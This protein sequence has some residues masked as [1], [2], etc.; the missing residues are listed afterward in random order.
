[1]RKLKNPVIDGH[2]KCGVCHTVKPV[3]AFSMKKSLHGELFHIS[4]C[5]E[6]ICVYSTKLK[7]SLGVQPKKLYPIID[8]C[9]Q[10]TLCDKVKPVDQFGKMTRNISGLR[11]ACKECELE[12]SLIY[13]R[14]QGRV[15]NTFVVHP[16]IDGIKKCHICLKDLSIDN[17]YVNKKGYMKH[18]CKK[19]NLVLQKPLRQKYYK[20]DSEQLTDEYLRM[21]IFK[22]IPIKKKDIPEDIFHI[23]REKIKIQREL[24]QLNNLKQ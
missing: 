19:C 7:R 11:A 6:C 1:M 8:G 24:R 2:K 17:F 13:R 16:I 15:P 4:K 5:K 10:C 12:K 3:D 20:R 9:K 21:V 23:F 18:S 22:H 14:A